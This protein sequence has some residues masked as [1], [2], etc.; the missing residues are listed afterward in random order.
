M[1]ETERKGGREEGGRERSG[2][3][4]RPSKTKPKKDDKALM[5]PSKQSNETN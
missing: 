3:Q 1:I 5:S 2:R 4:R